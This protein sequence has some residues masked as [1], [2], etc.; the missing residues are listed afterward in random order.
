[1][2][3]NTSLRNLQLNSNSIGAYWDAS[4]KIDTPEGP[5]FLANALS[6]NRGLTALSMDWNWLGK[7]GAGA[8]VLLLSRNNT[9][10]SLSLAGNLVG[11]TGAEQIAGALRSNTT[12]TSLNLDSNALCDTGDINEGFYNDSGV[13]A[14][15]AVLE[16]SA[17][18]Y[19]PADLL[20]IYTGDIMS[21]QSLSGDLQCERRCGC[22][23]TA[24]SVRLNSIN[25]Q[26]AAS[27]RRACGS[28]VQLLI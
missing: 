26:T 6:V 12:L 24:L 18:L 9:L 22:A 20:T 13:L 19:A 5:L 2:G 28:R 4:T 10:R 23:L 15:A 11:A 16:E 8:V 17:G 25:A 7:A 21:S 3:H 27:L 1:M 14:I